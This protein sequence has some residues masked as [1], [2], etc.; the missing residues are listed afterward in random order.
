MLV[1]EKPI[2][3]TIE[4]RVRGSTSQMAYDAVASVEETMSM[5]DSIGCLRLDIT[6]EWVWLY[7]HRRTLEPVEVVLL[8]G[9]SD[10]C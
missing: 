2:T 4:F 7:A 10:W 5:Q 1:A 8:S 9:Y 6:Y 3:T